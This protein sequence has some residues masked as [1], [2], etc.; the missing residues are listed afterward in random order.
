MKRGIGMLYL[1][2]LVWTL[3][4]IYLGKILLEGDER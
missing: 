1:S 3:V 2:G 4:L